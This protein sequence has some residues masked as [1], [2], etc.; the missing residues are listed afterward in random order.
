LLGRAVRWFRD[1]PGILRLLVGVTLA[2]IFLVPLSRVT[3]VASALAFGVSVVVLTVRVARRGPVGRW[4][5][6]AAASLVI[7][8]ASWGTYNALRDEGG[9]G[10]SNT[11]TDESNGLGN[12]TP[13]NAGSFEDPTD[14]R[15]CLGGGGPEEYSG[16][17]LD[18]RVVDS[19]ESETASGAR[20]LAMVA[21][22]SLYE[23]L[24]AIAQNLAVNPDEYDAVEVTIFP[25]EW[26]FYTRSQGVQPL[27]G[28]M[29]FSYNTYYVAHSPAGETIIG[30]PDENLNECG[31]S[32]KEGGYK[33]GMHELY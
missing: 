5:M 12:Q 25:R 4:G 32:Y 15:L 10:R 3:L 13:N 17:A 23:D 33:W 21:G 27:P 14:T 11:G 24:D 18:F 31:S 30:L 29:D 20:V 6:V 28:G 9:A 2:L 8:L 1:L 26:A 16:P 22:T 7:T 19:E